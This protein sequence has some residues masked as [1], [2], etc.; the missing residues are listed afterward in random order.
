MPQFVNIFLN[1]LYI[2]AVAIARIPCKKAGA[3]AAQRRGGAH[4]WNGRDPGP[5]ANSRASPAVA[6][7]GSSRELLQLP[8]EK[9][10]VKMSQ[11]L[12]LFFGVIFLRCIKA[13]G[14][15]NLREGAHD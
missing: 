11:K 13:R 10:I 6:E 9:N 4:R 5:P 15:L 12:C 8:N 2:A 3:T 1:L 14:S 7:H